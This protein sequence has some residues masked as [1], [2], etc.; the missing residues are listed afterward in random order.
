MFNGVVVNLGNVNYARGT[1]K[2]MMMDAIKRVYDMA[3]L[4]HKTS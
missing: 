2:K 3:T 1:M 4:N